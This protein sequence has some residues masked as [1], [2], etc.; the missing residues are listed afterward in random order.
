MES[1]LYRPTAGLYKLVFTDKPGLEILA[2]GTTLAKL[3]KLQGMKL[4]LNEPDEKKKTAA[5][6]FFAKRIVRWNMAH[7]DEDEMDEDDIAEAGHCIHCGQTPGQAMVPSVQSLLCLEVAEVMGILF[8]YMSAIASVSQGKGM[9]GNGGERS[10]PEEAAMRM[11][12][13]MQNQSTLPMPN[14][15]SE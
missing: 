9:S 13:E 7:P 6:R 12:A 4:Q 11:L 5:F 10:T 2:K 14:L 15:S 1:E 8:G 3:L